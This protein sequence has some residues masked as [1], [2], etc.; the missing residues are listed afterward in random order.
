MSFSSSVVREKDGANIAS[1]FD[2]LAP[3][4]FI[5]D[6]DVSKIYV[7][8]I[9]LLISLTYAVFTALIYFNFH[10]SILYIQ[11]SDKKAAQDYLMSLA[12]AVMFGLSMLAPR[13]AIGLFFVLAVV[14][15]QKKRNVTRKF[16]ASITE[17]IFYLKTDKRQVRSWRDDEINA[18]KGK[19]QL[20]IERS[21]KLVGHTPA[22]WLSSSTKYWVYGL[23]LAAIILQACAF[24]DFFIGHP[25]NPLLQWIALGFLHGG[26]ILVLPVG[27]IHFL[28]SA[29]ETLSAGDNED[30]QE[31]VD[32][33]FI[34]VLKHSS[35]LFE[36]TQ[37]GE[38]L[39]PLPAKYPTAK[40]SADP[41]PVIRKAS[42]EN[43]ADSSNDV[44]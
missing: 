11:R 33:Q 21:M 13:Y 9:Y 19:I 6:P 32:W 14:V 16:L 36:N 18:E 38:S 42:D 1:Y 28:G 2:P 17:Y 10:Q 37:T 35:S 3:L 5:G 34:S 24:V 8:V 26:S 31:A 22:S 15:L 27:L 43:A 20:E 41:S 12:V 25:A 30:Y 4:R 44:G 7:L 39:K 29:T 23:V 40:N